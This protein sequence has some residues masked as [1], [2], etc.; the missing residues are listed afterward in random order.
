MMKA[1]FY[2]IKNHA[3]YVADFQGHAN[4]DVLGKDVVCAGASMF[5]MGLAQ[6][7]AQMGADGKLQKKPNIKIKNGSV[8]IVAKP[9]PQHEEELRHFF[10]MAQ[11]GM[12]ILE[13]AYPEHVEINL[14]EASL[15]DDSE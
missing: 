15:K 7:V 3:A 4:F 1:S 14:Y 2:R 12:K 11:V 8:F 9:K 6:C 5:V 10:Y 13:S